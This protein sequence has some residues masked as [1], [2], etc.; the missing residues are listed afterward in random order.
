MIDRNCIPPECPSCF[1][2]FSQVSVA[3]NSPQFCSSILI[4]APAVASS[5]LL[6][7]S[8]GVAISWWWGPLTLPIWPL[9]GWNISS[10][11]PEQR[12]DQGMPFY[13]IDV[14][15]TKMRYSLSESIVLRASDSRIKIWTFALP[16][17][18]LRIAEAHPLVLLMGFSR[19]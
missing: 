18:G 12:Q 11:S 14:T 1:C 2:D 7:L 13:K 16:Q 10:Y 19:P 6:L 3:H 15:N 9:E 5:F 17:V 4:L 8:V